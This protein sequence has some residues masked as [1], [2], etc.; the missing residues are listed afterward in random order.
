MHLFQPQQRRWRRPSDST[1]LLTASNFHFSSTEGASRGSCLRTG[2]HLRNRQAGFRTS[3]NSSYVVTEIRRVTQKTRYGTCGQP[4]RIP[5]STGPAISRGREMDAKKAERSVRVHI[6]AS[7]VRDTFARILFSG[8]GRTRPC[9]PVH[10]YSCYRG[11]RSFHQTRPSW[12]RWGEAN[13]RYSC[14]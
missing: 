6:S 5:C 11:S 12:F 7:R 8:H 1:P 3:A 10:W 2:A 9:F 4:Q 14:M 13:Q